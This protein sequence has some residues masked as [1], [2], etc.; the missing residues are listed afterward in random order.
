MRIF[1]LTIRFEA[2]GLA[3]VLMLAA[4][5]GGV[6]ACT[7]APAEPAAPSPSAAVERAGERLAMADM[8]VDGVPLFAGRDVFIE[9]FGEPLSRDIQESAATGEIQEI[10]VYDFGE[11][12]FSQG[13]DGWRWIGITVDDPGVIGPRGIRVGSTLE[14][15]FAAFPGQSGDGDE[16]RVILYRYNDE[17]AN[18]VAVPPSG[19]MD[20]TDGELS[21]VQYDFPLDEQW[22]GDKSMDE[23]EA[24]YVYEP[25]ALLRFTV[26][27][28][29][30][31]GFYIF[32]G[33]YAE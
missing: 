1:T 2:V 14:E 8:V 10:Y 32:T 3:A 12:V 29:I 20:Y 13:E 4:L 31:T 30:V 18:S 21:S 19:V 17:S 16:E 24:A 9:R 23:I 26:E 27:D 11:A 22:F 5:L 15:L 33:A 25:H 6:S 28:E 7:A